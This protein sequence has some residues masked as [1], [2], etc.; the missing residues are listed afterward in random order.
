MRSTFVTTF[1][2]TAALVLAVT[3]TPAAGGTQLFKLIPSDGRVEEHFGISVGISGNTVIVGTTIAEAAYLYNASTG[4]EIAILVS[5]DSAPSD[6]FGESVGISG[7][8]CIV[9]ARW[10]EDV[11]LGSTYLYEL[12]CGGGEF[13]RGDADGDG[14]FNGLVDGLFIFNY[15]FSG[16]EAPPCME[17]ADADDSGTFSGLVD[18]IYALNHQFN[19]G[20]PPGAP[21]PDCGV[22]PEPAMGIGCVTSACP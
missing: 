22:D 8:K 16:G 21:H 13:L 9:G 1:A 3:P 15:Q 5:N 10:N 11:G 12:A 20:P 4:Q 2:M 19:G 17:A 7:T 18:G 14:S 6:L